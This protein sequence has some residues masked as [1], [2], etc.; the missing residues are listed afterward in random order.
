MSESGATIM[1]PE[2]RLP[3]EPAKAHQEDYH[4]YTAKMD[5]MVDNLKNLSAAERKRQN[6]IFFIWLI[7]GT[8][9]ILLSIWLMLNYT[10]TNFSGNIIPY[11]QTDQD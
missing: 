5:R 10:R 4:E 7:V 3:D 6:R 9:I 8:L 2:N 11:Y 1:E